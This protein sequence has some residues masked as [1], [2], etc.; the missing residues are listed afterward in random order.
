MKKLKHCNFC[1][2]SSL[3]VKKLIAGPDN[4][5]N[6][7]YICNECIDLSHNAIHGKLHFKKD[8]NKEIHF[9]PKEIKEY[10]DEY[11]IGQS[12]A[13]E[14]LAVAVYNH[15]K[16]INNPI[17]NGTV[18]NKSNV[19]MLGPSGTGKTLMVSTLSKML[20]VPFVHVDATSLTE[21]GYVG[22]DVESIIA[23]LLAEADGD[24]EKAEKGIVYIDEIDK[25]VKKGGGTAN[26]KDVSGEG[27]QQALLKLIEGKKLKV[28]KPGSR[29]LDDPN[30][31]VDT[32]NILFIAAGA[33][34]GLDENKNKKSVGFGA[35]H[36]QKDATKEVTPEDLI[37]YGLIP[38]FV[39]RF[40]I[41]TV[42][43]SLDKDMLV[44]VM[45]KPKNCIVDQYVSLF[46]LD[47]VD[48]VFSES[49]ID[50]I[51]NAS[52]KKKV[53][54]RG[55]QGMFEKDLQ[56]IQFS[57]PQLRET[58]VSE[59]VIS[60]EGKPQYIYKKERGSENE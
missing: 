41:L 17:V 4:G 2:K 13:K 33:F 22:E 14:S 56:K 31:T 46:H 6:T 16:R 48:L 40:P 53:G 18:L 47:G 29:T 21:A 55:L 9:T 37:Q 23:R 1:G 8:S 58:G 10:L 5:E 25:K 54:A 39:G 3:E 44:E 49:Y 32:T 24:V 51:A 28:V 59:I 34:V 12:Q 27:V 30:V 26:S 52:V 60:N 42:L 7:V 15:Y 50:K 35:N 57:L 19:I 45:T 38:E 43:H 36:S 11:V 20:N